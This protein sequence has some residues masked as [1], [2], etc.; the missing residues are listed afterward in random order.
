MI[1]AL[2]AHLMALTTLLHE[3]GLVPIAAVIEEIQ[4]IGV[5]SA[6]D[7]EHQPDSDF[8]EL[9]ADLQRHADALGAFQA[10]ED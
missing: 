5:T 2:Q 1:F 4:E 8:V 10:R 6:V 7:L 3:R 9:L